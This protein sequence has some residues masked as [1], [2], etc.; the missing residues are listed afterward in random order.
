MAPTSR[1]VA[2]PSSDNSL[3]Q[4]GRSLATIEPT[5]Q[6]WAGKR[7]R[8]YAQ[9]EIDR[10]TAD[11]AK[12]Q[13]A[14]GN[15]VR[16]GLLA[17]GASKFYVN[18]TMA[19]DA[20]KHAEE[21][22]SSLVDAWMQSDTHTSDDPH[23]FEK[24][25]SDFTTKYNSDHLNSATDGSPKYTPAQLQEAQY[26]QTQ[27]EAINQLR[28]HNT[29]IRIDERTQAG[30]D[31]YTGLAVAGLKNA[32]VG[33]DGHPLEDHEID[34][35]K[36]AFDLKQA[37]NAFYK[38][39]GRNSQLTAMDTTVAMA[40]SMETGNAYLITKAGEAMDAMRPSAYPITR[41]TEWMQKAQAAKE[42]IANRQQVA[43]TEQEA[44]VKLI[45]KGATWQDRL[46]KYQ[47][48]EDAHVGGLT[49]IM[50]QQKTTV[51]RDA[52]MGAVLD[53]S[54]P[55]PAELATRKD[56]LLKLKQFD[57]SA[58]FAVEKTLS[59]LEH[60][61]QLE[62]T[63]QAQ[64]ISEM[65]LSR[66]VI[67]NPTSPQ[68]SEMIDFALRDHT[69]TGEAHRR[70]QGMQ[71]D[72]RGPMKALFADPIMSHAIQSI[73]DAAILIWRQQREKRVRRRGSQSIRPGPRRA[74]MLD[75]ILMPSRKKWLA[76]SSSTEPR[77]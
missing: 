73:H 49:E 34:L 54:N 55:T 52:A 19:L 47:M 2:V 75:H 67:K 11:S 3:M 61:K 62:R 37:A 12:T 65:N 30:V 27:T 70:L 14:M 33:P 26:S 9:S 22:Q 72:V 68:T 28:L 23:A 74:P 35:T 58:G 25:A 1:E 42:H 60:P 41:T 77:R 44:R 71:D 66:I 39:G 7:G 4:L 17:G 50:R 6:V 40:T 63:K 56:A 13:T 16:E 53:E 64:D 51:L 21:F 20:K 15:V 24:F 69:I 48:E 8:E 18:T 36:W 38:A 46:K 57:G 5:V 45:A 29:N 31:A 59:E 43:I 32:M 76:T 10:A